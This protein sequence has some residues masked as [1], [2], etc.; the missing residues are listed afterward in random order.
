[1]AS[2]PELHVQAAGAEKNGAIKRILSEWKAMQ[3]D[4]GKYGYQTMPSEDD[5]FEWHFMFHGPPDT[6]FSGGVYAG[7]INLPGEYPFKPPE[8]R[9]L[10]PNGRFELNK[11]I[12]LSISNYH[13]EHWQPSWDIRTIITAL[14]A[15]MPSEGAGAI[16]SLDFPPEERKKLA[17]SSRSHAHHMFD[18]Q[19]FLK[20][21]PLPASIPDIEVKAGNPNDP[22]T[23]KGTHTAQAA[24]VT[25][26]PT[27][28]DVPAEDVPVPT[29]APPSPCLLYTSDA[30]D[31]EDS[32]DLGGRRIIKKKK[33]IEKSIKTMAHIYKET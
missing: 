9:I 29:I 31:E 27:A 7:R 6:D 17:V 22:K 12:C 19:E 20:E 5:I 1:M 10:T 32:V 24:N 4:N 21:V 14:I 28:N 18:P 11:K 33:K 2:S 25:L 26:D 3:S 30:A 13:P 15:F 8:I 23:P 16:G